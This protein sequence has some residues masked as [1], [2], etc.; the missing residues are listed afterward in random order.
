MEQYE[1]VNAVSGPQVL[2]RAAID[3]VKQWR[4]QPSLLNG[5]PVRVETEIT[6]NFKKP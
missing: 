6:V 5:T 3:A 4:Y 1:Q 2:A